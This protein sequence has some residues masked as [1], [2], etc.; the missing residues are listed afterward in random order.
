MRSG[1]PRIVERK[2]T[3]ISP[4]VT[5]LEKSVQFAAGEPTHLYHCVT[6]ADYVGVLAVTADGLVPIV[7]QYRPTVEDF[8]WEFPAGTIDEGETAE[9]TARRELQEEAGLEVQELINL[10]CFIPDTGRLQVNSH[11]FFA[12]A[13]R[14]VERVEPEPGIEIRFVTVPELREMMRTLQFRHQVHLAIYASALLQGVCP[15]LA[16]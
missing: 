9:Q 2:R 8:T 7:R 4:F 15:E 13:R 1:Y 11:A 6:Q 10:G 12:R 5:L 3:T 16:L 14:P